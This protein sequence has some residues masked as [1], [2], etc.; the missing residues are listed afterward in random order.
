[1]WASNAAGVTKARWQRSQLSRELWW[2]R[3]WLVSEVC[4]LNVREQLGHLKGFSCREE[5]GVLSEHLKKICSKDD[6]IKKK[7]FPKPRKKFKNLQNQ[8][9]I[10]GDSNKIC[11]EN[12]TSK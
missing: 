1:L 11:E 2:I 6:D 9:K 12:C 4:R 10:V 8:R 5:N 3:M 7:D